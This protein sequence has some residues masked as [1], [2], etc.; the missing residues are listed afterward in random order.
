MKPSHPLFPPSLPHSIH[1]SQVNILK[2]LRNPFI[3]RFYD[4]VI[5]RATKKC[6]I[7]ME[8]CPVRSPSS[9]I[10]PFLPRNSFHPTTHLLPFFPPSH[11]PSRVVT[12]GV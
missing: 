8:Y 2:D 12:S 3:V 11:P 9:S 4:H 6:Y 10:P 5:E 7:V 1:S